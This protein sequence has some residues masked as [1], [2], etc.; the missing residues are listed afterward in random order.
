M[1]LRRLRSEVWVLTGEER[2]SHLPLSVCLYATTQEYKSTLQSLIFDSFQATYL[3]R[4]W[5]WKAFRGLPPAAAGCSVVIAEVHERHVKWMGKS[6]GIVIPAWVRGHVPLPRG[7]EVMKRFSIKNILRKIRQQKLESEATRDAQ[8]F[9]YFYHR[10]YVPYAKARFGDGA[11]VFPWDETKAKFDRGELVMVRQR[12]E[13]IAGE[14]IVYGE[15]N[16]A[17]MPLL[18]VLDGSWEI[19][20]VGALAAT[21]EFALQHLEKRGCRTVDFGKTQAF[22]NDGVLRFKK[23]FGHVIAGGSEHK[24]L[25]SVTRDTR[26]ARAFLESNPFLFEHDGGLRGAVFVDQASPTPEVLLEVYK[27]QY[28]LGLLEI[29]VF[30][31]SQDGPGGDD[32]PDPQRAWIPA[33][34][35]AQRGPTY[36][37]LAKADYEPFLRRLG[38]LGIAAAVSI[39]EGGDR[40]R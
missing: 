34:D 18:G 35:S 25:V 33:T 38:P 5:L 15:G 1:R 4:G 9:D 7:H 3:G 26:A 27:E 24:Y 39:C 40:Q 19:V 30:F 11:F 8:V 36:Q 12:G 6:S 28:Q 37:V 32:Q 31:F 16:T 10:M 14:L 21:Y 22:L 13:Y 17:F 20:A 23:K 29:V 2:N